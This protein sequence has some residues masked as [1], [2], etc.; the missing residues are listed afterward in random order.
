MIYVCKWQF[1]AKCGQDKSIVFNYLIRNTKCLHLWYNFIFRYNSVIIY[2]PQV[3]KFI[4]NSFIIIM[5]SLIIAL[6]FPH[7]LLVRQVAFLPPPPN[8]SP[9]T[10]AIWQT[11]ISIPFRIPRKPCDSFI[12]LEKI[13]YTFVDIGC[14]KTDQQMRLTLYT[15]TQH[16][17]DSEQILTI[18]HPAPLNNCS[19]KKTVCV[20]FV[21]D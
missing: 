10:Y 17:N 6:T 16:M 11:F 20:C 9:I 13:L 18:S 1:S 7:F 8:V 21:G 5:K 15:H 12:W 2:L 3:K 19:D 14:V 4:L